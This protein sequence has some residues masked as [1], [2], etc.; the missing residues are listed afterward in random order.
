MEIPK[1]RLITF[2]Y[3]I[4]AVGAVF[5]AFFLVVYLGGLPT[6]DV[7]HELPVFRYPLL[8]LGAV[9]LALVIGAVVLAALR[10]R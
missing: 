8:G 2:L 6:T 10:R 1:N 3:S 7:L 5:A 4:E 9:L